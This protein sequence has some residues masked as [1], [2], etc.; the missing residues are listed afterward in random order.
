MKNII[1]LEK[2]LKKQ[3]KSKIKKE[4][5]AL[6][7]EFRAHI[8]KGL[9]EKF[10]HLPPSMMDEVEEIIEAKTIEA[11]NAQND[12]EAGKTARVVKKEVS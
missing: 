12:A 1:N 3:R 8:W 6:K 7:K 10:G 5:D 11:I 9:V 4:E 2:A